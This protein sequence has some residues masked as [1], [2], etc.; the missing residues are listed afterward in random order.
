MG[1][2]LETL[3]ER[4]HAQ[5]FSR[6]P[7]LVYWIQ[8]WFFRWLGNGPYI[9]GIYGFIVSL[10]ILFGL[11]LFWQRV[12]CDEQLDKAGSWWPLLLL[13]SLPVITY[14]V[15]TNRLVVTFLPFAIFATYF[16]YLSISK[17]RIWLLHALLAGVL[18]YLGG[19]AKGPVALFSLAVPAIGWLTLKVP[20]SR[21]FI[22]TAVA[23]LTCAMIFLG[24]SLPL[25][26]K[27]RFLERILAIAGCC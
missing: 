8:S 6:A 14:M 21:A 3:S 2:F 11:A 1:Y 5:G 20:L 24:T 16:S 7:P 17:S 18:I 9:E 12:R 23:L 27:P 10:V 25:P 15:Q 22:S 4:N 26:R 13:I 19:I